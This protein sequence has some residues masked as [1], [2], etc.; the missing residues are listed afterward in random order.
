MLSRFRLSWKVILKNHF[1]SLAGG[2]FCVRTSNRALYASSPLTFSPGGLSLPIPDR[3]GSSSRKIT[4]RE[5]LQTGAADVG[6]MQGAL[7]F[8]YVLCYVM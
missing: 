8:R 3:L 4:T 5:G 6:W 7:F 2:F 1:P